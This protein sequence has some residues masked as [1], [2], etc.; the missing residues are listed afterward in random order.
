MGHC[1]NALPTHTF[2]LLTSY[3]GMLQMKSRGILVGFGQSEHLGFAVKLSQKSKTHGC[4]RAAWYQIAVLKNVGHGSSIAA[5]AIRKDHCRMTSEVGNDK[6][7]GPGRSD[8]H[9]ELVED[10]SH[11]FDGHHASAVGLNVLDRGDEARSAEDVGP[12][13]F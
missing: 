10:P 8:D 1:Q 2:H 13:I 9:I 3:F 4:A 11:G 12:V 7:R 5:E 6:L